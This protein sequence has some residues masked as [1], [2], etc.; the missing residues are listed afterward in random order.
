MSTRVETA[1]KS[2]VLLAPETVHRQLPINFQQADLPLF[3]HELEKSLPATKLVEL[4]DVSVSADGILFQGLHILPASFAFPFLQDQWRTRSRVKF[5]VTNHLLRKRRRFEQD[6]LWLTDD[7]SLGYFHWLSDVLSKLYAM[8]DRINDFVLLLPAQYQS[9]PFVEASLNAFEVNKIEF[10]Q[11]NEV[12]TVDRLTIATPIAPSGHFREDVIKGV[13][14]VLLERY[15]A[16]QR[17]ARRLYLSRS[18]AP[19]RR[20]VNEVEVLALMRELGFEIVFAEDLTFSEQVNLASTA[21]LLVSNHGAGLTNMLFLPEG[22]NVLELRH[23]NDA[24]NN[25]YFTLASALG[26]NYFYQK[27]ASPDQTEDAHTADL[28]VDTQ[29]LRENLQGMGLNSDFFEA[30]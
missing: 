14:R 7:W 10:I 5:L 3:A 8:R 17:P 9:A 11:P 28:I 19:K 24:V 27:C 2:T 22:A 18:R 30:H 13:R 16:K 15:G 25:C 12:L 29:E 23:R 21:N 1:E 20:V 26:L 6:A 4:E